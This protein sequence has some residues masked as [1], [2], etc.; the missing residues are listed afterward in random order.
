MYNI[1]YTTIR[2]VLYHPQKLR[3]DKLKYKK[4]N[5]NISSKNNLNHQKKRKL[6][7]KWKK[8]FFLPFED[9]GIISFVMRNTQKSFISLLNF[10]FFLPSTVFIYTKKKL[11][12]AFHV[13][14]FFFPSFSNIFITF[15][16]KTHRKKNNIISKPQVNN[17]LMLCLIRKYYRRRKKKSTKVHT[18]IK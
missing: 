14:F 4:K 12:I 13:F 16:K 2:Y 5:K 18:H 9:E 7:K 6:Y 1:R 11:I 8:S 15:V 3:V 17:F 10:C